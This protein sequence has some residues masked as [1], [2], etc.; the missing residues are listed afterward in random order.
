MG[1][2]SN[3]FFDRFRYSYPAFVAERLKLLLET[4][5]LYQK[6]SITPEVTPEARAKLKILVGEQEDYDKRVS[7]FSLSKFSLAENQLFDEHRLPTPCLIVGNVKLFC[8]KCD[9]REAFRPVWFV[10]I[11]NQLLQPLVVKDSK[12][13]VAFQSSFQ[14]FALVFQCQRCQGLPEVFIV[15]RNG[16]DLSLEGRSPIEHVEIPKFIP[17]DE[18]KWFRD[19]VIAF[20]TGKT[21]AALFYLRTF[22]EQFAR[23][24]TNLRTD[25][26][27][28]DEIMTAYAE[29]LPVE[30]RSSMPSLAEW[31]DKLSGALH[32]ANEDSELFESAQEK[33]EKHFDIRRVHELDSRPSKPSKPES[34]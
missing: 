20:Q 16:Y 2:I 30:L 27:T 1:H 12:F 5:H 3:D 19:A 22:I 8:S 18:R 17:Q 34:A 24:K 25:K 14:L 9:S 15:K 32:T 26:R 7:S 31:Y 28:G 11:T 4:C 29:T 21:L 10:D 23:R 6:V 33:I 13:K